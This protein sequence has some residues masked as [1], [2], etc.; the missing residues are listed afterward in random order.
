MPRRRPFLPRRYASS[1]APA[2]SGFHRSPRGPDPSRASGRPPQKLRV[3]S[4][5]TVS[6][7]RTPNTVFG[8]GSMRFRALLAVMAA[9]VLGSMFSTGAGAQGRGQQVTLPDGPGKEMVQATCTKCHGLNM[10]TG[11]WGNDKAGW[12]ALFGTMVAVPKD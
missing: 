1:G 3:S 5:T 6:S 11:S 12:E 2:T 7:A 8:G 4:Q 9:V 10:I